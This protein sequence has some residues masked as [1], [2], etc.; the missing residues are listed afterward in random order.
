MNANEAAEIIIAA[1]GEDRPLDASDLATAL[2]HLG[3]LPQPASQQQNQSHELAATSHHRVDPTTVS[4]PHPTTAGQINPVNIPQQGTQRL[5][6]SW[7]R[8]TDPDTPTGTA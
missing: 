2:S 4:A 1:I 6:Q 5:N 3:L 7:Q 8:I